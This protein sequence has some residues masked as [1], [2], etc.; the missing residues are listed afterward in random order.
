MIIVP[1]TPGAAEAISSWRYPA[2]YDCYSFSP[3]RQLTDELLAGDYFA[4]WEQ[5]ELTGYFCFGAAARIPLASPVTEGDPYVRP[6]L[7]IGLG[8]RPDCCGKGKGLCFLKEGLLF[9][10]KTFGPAAPFRLAV[11]EGNQRAKT[12]YERAGFTTVQRV[13]H[14][15]GTAF[16]IMERPCMTTE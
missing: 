11:M 10:H 2:P 5:G 15:S 7:D 13:L 4:A 8:L 16:L 14:R 3:S 1:M 9:A 12:V 6:G